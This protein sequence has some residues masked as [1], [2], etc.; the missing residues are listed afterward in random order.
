MAGRP[1]EFDRNEALAK[2]RD[3]FWSHGYEGTSI[4]DLVAALG[5]ASSRIYAAF[6]TKEE[7]FREAVLLYRDGEGGRAI[8]ALQAG[9]T[10]TEG[11]EQMLRVAIATYTQPGRPRGCMVVIA[12]ANCSA[13]NASVMNWL[14][15]HRRARTQA[16][17]D[18]LQ[19]GVED[20]EL[21]PLADVAALADYFSA[22]MSGFSTQA[23][24][25]VSR[26]KLLAVIP[27]AMRVLREQQH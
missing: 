23:R 25:G 7:L 12:A 11:I 10:V 5:L 16:I 20:G 6:G 1:R 19:K 2:A 14:A 24:D 27:M 15:G 8:K 26:G 13:D 18:R 3:A 9:S 22:L 4:N 17:F 21:P